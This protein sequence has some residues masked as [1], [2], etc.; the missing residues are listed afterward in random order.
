MPGKRS[1][2]TKKVGKSGKLHKSHKNHM[3]NT[4]DAHNILSRLEYLIIMLTRMY[5][6]IKHNIRVKNKGANGVKGDK[7]D[8]DGKKAENNN[9][10]ESELLDRFNT[11]KNIENIQNDS[12]IDTHKLLQF[13]NEI[14]RILPSITDEI[15][16]SPYQLDEPIKKQKQSGGFYFRSLEDKGDKPITG[17]DLSTL[18]D[19]IQQFFYNAKY[20]EEGG[21]FRDT[22]TLISLLRGDTETFKFWLRYNI[23]PKYY[24]LYPPFLKFGAIK[25]AIENKKY[26]DYPD[27][28]LTYKSYTDSQNQYLI[29]KGLATPATVRSKFFDNF[30]TISDQAMTAVAKARR[31]NPKHAIL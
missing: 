16:R 27:Y 26:E 25:Q 8:N 21:A 20:T 28:L 15:I 29:D 4:D 22:D 11:I 7:G 23:A 31:I 14:C 3:K 5:I 19:E 6:D 1:K 9:L 17:A 2:V 24:M 18:L 10:I 12:E 30:S 13:T